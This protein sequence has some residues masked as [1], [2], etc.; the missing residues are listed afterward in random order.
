MSKMPPNRIQLLGVAGLVVTVGLAA[1]A[2]AASRAVTGSR[3][4]AK[5]AQANFRIAYTHSGGP[6]WVRR[7]VFVMNADGSEQRNLSRAPGRD[8]GHAWSPDGRKIVF[9]SRRDGK[10]EIYFVNADGSGLRNLT[11]SPAHD[12]APAWSPDG[13]KIVFTRSRDFF[14][15]A[16]VELYVMNADGSGER[17]LTRVLGRGDGNPVWSLPGRAV[18]SPDGRRL[19]F[20][21]K[22][23]GNFDIYVMN[24]DGSGLRNLTRNPARDFFHTWL[25]DGRI[26]FFS[27]RDGTSQQLFVMRTRT[28]AGCGT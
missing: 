2:G 27:E 14:M 4:A 25:P 28:G 23:E 17:R 8:N 7:D 3:L 15:R 11:R 10:Q 19:A 5:S 20:S 13:R 1:A 16:N 12:F 24:A 9:V 21:A 6:L 22:R 18:W 26:A